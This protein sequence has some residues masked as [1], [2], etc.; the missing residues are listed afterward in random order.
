VEDRAEAGYEDEADQRHRLGQGTHLMA[1]TAPQS[2]SLFTNAVRPRGVYLS[3]P[4][5]VFA[6]WTVREYGGIYFAAK[7]HDGAAGTEI[8]LPVAPDNIFDFDVAALTGDRAVVVYTDNTH[9]KYFVYDFRHADHR[10]HDPGHG[11]RSGDDQRRQS[12]HHVPARQH[13]QDDHG[14]GW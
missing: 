5:K 14:P 12:A 13:R 4:G 11:P 3:G 7:Q 9:I 2:L 8:I 10:H 6:V 1:L